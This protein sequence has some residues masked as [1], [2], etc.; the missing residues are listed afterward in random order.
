[1]SYMLTKYSRWLTKGIHLA[2]YKKICCPVLQSNFLLTKRN[3][4]L[5]RI[6]LRAHWCCII[7]HHKCYDCFSRWYHSC[8]VHMRNNCSPIWVMCSLRACSFRGLIA[9]Y[10]PQPTSTYFNL[11]QPTWKKKYQLQP[12]STYLNLLHSTSTNF[13]LPLS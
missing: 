3:V 8:Y 13:N 2:Y 12:T 1:M 5:I 6:D 7:A 9:I 11:L 4:W 10:Q